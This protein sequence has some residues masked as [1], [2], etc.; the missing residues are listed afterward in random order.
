MVERY[1]LSYRNGAYYLSEP[2]E[3][4][5]QLVDAHEYDRLT[6]LIKE[7]AVAL[8]GSM[9]NT[10]TRTSITRIFGSAPKCAQTQPSRNTRSNSHD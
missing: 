1:S 10:K 3:G 5:A 4:G 6:S 9:P 8:E 7:M 2:L